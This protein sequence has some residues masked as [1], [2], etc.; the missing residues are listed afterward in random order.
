MRSTTDGL[1][2]AVVNGETFSGTTLATG[3]HDGHGTVDITGLEPGRLYT[4]QLFVAGV[5]VGEQKVKT[6]PRGK[7][8]IA[9][10]SCSSTG[11]GAY[12]AVRARE[13]SP[14]VMV[15]LGDWPYTDGAVNPAWVLGTTVNSGDACLDVET[16]AAHHRRERNNY[17]LRVL[18]RSGVP[19]LYMA[20]DHEWAGD[21]YDHTPD[22]AM[23]GNADI[24]N[25]PGISDPPTQAQVD[26]AWWAGRQALIPF[27]ATNPRNPDPQA[28]AEKPSEAAAGTPASQY[29]VAY[30]WVAND[31]VELVLQDHISYRSAV[32]DT[33]DASKTMMGA[34]QKARYKAR[35]LASRAAVKVVLTPKYLFPLS[36]EPAGG[37]RWNKYS[38]ER[39]ELLDF[40]GD[41]GIVGVVYLAG[42]KHTANMAA[43]RVAEGHA[44]DAACLTCCPCGVNTSPSDGVFGTYTRGIYSGSESEVDQVI[45]M[46]DCDKSGAQLNLVR[47]Q[48]GTVID[49]G[50]V[51]SSSNAWVAPAGSPF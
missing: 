41:N 16:Y 14:D 19:I 39:A 44:W 2:S 43:A 33:D 18:T 3:T 13:H 29:P 40:V 30:T 21:D 34:T 8:R 51:P 12:W 22:A 32:A 1:L 10:A 50:R 15:V 37:D 46:V 23:S 31:T 6:W 49:C 17:W 45:G 38:T 42:D 35:M 5:A 36:N 47:V 4:A 20:D 28:V 27:Y 9:V 11:S 7:L 24:R 25:T 26:A 48:D